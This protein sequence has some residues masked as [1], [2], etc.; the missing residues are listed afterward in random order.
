MYVCRYLL[1]KFQSCVAMWSMYVI[2][3]F[4]EGSFFKFTESL[5]IVA[6]HTTKPNDARLC[7]QDP[8]TLKSV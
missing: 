1:Q 2:R 4:I 3:K 8:S 7:F 5:S 6:K